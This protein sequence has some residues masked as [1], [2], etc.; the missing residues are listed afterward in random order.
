MEEDLVSLSVSEDDEV[1]RSVSE[2]S[3]ESQWGWD[4]GNTDD[5]RVSKEGTGEGS[6]S[7]TGS[8]SSDEPDA[9]NEEQLR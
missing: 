3:R 2:R 9:P 5:D 7:A 8:E 6:V 1:E 4:E